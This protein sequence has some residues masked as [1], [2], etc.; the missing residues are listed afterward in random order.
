MTALIEGDATLSM[1]LY[2]RT[3][4]TSDEQ[5]QYQNGSGT[6]S[7]IDRAPLVVRDEV[8]FPYN[9]GAL[10]AIRL[11]QSGGFDAVNAAFLDPPRSTEQIIHP[12]KY[13]AHEQP[14]EVTLPDLPA[15][16]GAGWTQL[17]SDVLGEL[18]VRIMI[19]Q[20][21]GPA[22][23]ASAAEGWGG[24]RYAYLENASGQSAIALS[25][26]W[27]S[28]AEADRVLQRLCRHGWQPLRQ[29]R[30]PNRRQPGQRASG[31]RQTAPSSSSAGGRTWR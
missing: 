16:L 27:D 3:Y 19:E 29:S 11:W 12:E 2:A 15:A 28:E 1:I 10:F 4:L 21:S 14:I 13:L 22:V 26:V 6:Q 31:S 8:V 23:G 20:F 18:D 30:P 24:D 17:R 25:T 5:A 7:T 9:E